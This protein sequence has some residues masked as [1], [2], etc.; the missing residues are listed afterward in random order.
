M[1]AIGRLTTQAAV[2]RYRQTI[3]QRAG[4]GVF[5]DAA[6]EELR[7][8]LAERVAVIERAESAAVATLTPADNPGTD[9]GGP[10]PWTT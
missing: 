6:A 9:D 1:L 7:R 10:D 4:M 8:L 2:E 5:T 3:D